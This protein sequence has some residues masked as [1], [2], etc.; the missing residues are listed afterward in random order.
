MVYLTLISSSDK[1]TPTFFN[2]LFESSNIFI[3]STGASLVT[4]F[5]LYIYHF[6]CYILE[7]L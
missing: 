7:V 1:L 3:Q 2:N 6:H 4:L 5:Q